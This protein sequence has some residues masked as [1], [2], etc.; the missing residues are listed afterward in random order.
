MAP[1]GVGVVSLPGGNERSH[2]LA[3]LV[4]AFGVGWAMVAWVLRTV[5]EERRRTSGDGEANDED[6]LSKP[7]LQTPKS[8][9]ALCFAI[10]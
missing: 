7:V 1:I 6:W 5:D 9:E 8:P 2:P 4:I 10:G 3:L